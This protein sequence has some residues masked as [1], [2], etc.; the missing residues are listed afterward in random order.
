MNQEENFSEIFMASSFETSLTPAVADCLAEYCDRRELARLSQTCRQLRD[1]RKYGDDHTPHAAQKLRHLA[2]T[3]RPEEFIRLADRLQQTNWEVLWEISYA[4]GCDAIDGHSWP[5]LEYVNSYYEKP[6][7]IFCSWM[8]HAIE[9]DEPEFVRWL[10]KHSINLDLNDVNEKIWATTSTEMLRVFLEVSDS[11]LRN[12]QC[13]KV[14]ENENATPEVLRMLYTLLRDDLDYKIEFINL[15]AANK[16]DWF[17]AEHLSEDFSFVIPAAV[18]HG[19]HQVY[20]NTNGWNDEM[21]D[22]LATA[23]ATLIATPTDAIITSLATPPLAAV[24]IDLPPAAIA[25]PLAREGE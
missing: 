23:L 19:R 16:A 1:I 7:E 2:H 3:N 8:E 12:D 17:L 21:M 15:A 14:W 9:N 11:D 25:P 24:P 4:V 13:N 10:G 5:I 6:F 22:V 18:K 20:A